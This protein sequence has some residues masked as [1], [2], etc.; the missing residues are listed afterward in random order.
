MLNLRKLTNATDKLILLVLLRLDDSRFESLSEKQSMPR[1]KCLMVD[2]SLAPWRDRFS[3]ISLFCNA[4]SRIFSIEIWKKYASIA[5]LRSQRRPRFATKF[6][7]WG[8]SV[9]VVHYQRH[10]GF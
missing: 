6:P 10:V 7:M 5:R 3:C 2:A 4:L 1:T 8:E 9:R